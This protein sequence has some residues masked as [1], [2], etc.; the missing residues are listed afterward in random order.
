MTRKVL[1]IQIFSSSGKSSQKLSIEEERNLSRDQAQQNESRIK[2]LEEA[3]SRQ[4][5]EYE[6]KLNLFDKKLRIRKIQLDEAKTTFIDEKADLTQMRL[7]LETLLH[8]VNLIHFSYYS[9]VP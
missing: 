8:Q 2:Q 3:N 5:L 4:Q 6:T 7:N 1:P 9:S